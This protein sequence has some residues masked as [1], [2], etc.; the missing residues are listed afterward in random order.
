MAWQ[1]SDGAAAR[2]TSLKKAVKSADKVIL[3]TDPDRE[4]EAIIGTQEIFND[5]N[6][7]KNIETERVVFN[8]V[9]KGAILRAMEQP[10]QIDTNLVDAYLARRALD[11]LVGFGISPILWRKLLRA[12]CWPSP[13]CG[14]SPNRRA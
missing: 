4:G 11:Y 10:R 3:A 7:L 5:A 12:F 13:V 9:T 1:L 8:E 2:I 6:L 14:T